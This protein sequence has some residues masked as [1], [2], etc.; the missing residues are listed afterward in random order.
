MNCAFESV[1][2][3]DFLIK[4]HKHLS[5]VHTHE[6]V[7]GLV[8]CVENYKDAHVLHVML[9][10]GTI[11]THTEPH[12]RLVECEVERVMGVSK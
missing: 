9:L 7:M 2:A 1:R 12:H 4:M 5:R 6:T 3:G 11:R 8:V 10:D